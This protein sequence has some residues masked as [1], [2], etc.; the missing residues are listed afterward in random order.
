[1]K[2]LKLVFIKKET[3]I[4]KIVL[5]EMNK[6]DKNHE[7]YNVSSAS[8]ASDESDFDSES[9]RSKKKSIDKIVEVF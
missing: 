9:N 1:V 2:N 8:E 5:F 3:L 4:Q 7:D 6:K